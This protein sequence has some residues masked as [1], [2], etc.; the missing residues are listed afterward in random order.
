MSETYDIEILYR[1]PTFEIRGPGQEEPFSWTYSL[2]A[3]SPDAA[4]RQALA[5]FRAIAAA[6]WVS[7]VRNIVELR[8]RSSSPQAG[9]MDSLIRSQL[10][11]ASNPKEAQLDEESRATLLELQDQLLEELLVIKWTRLRDAYLRSGRSGRRNGGLERALRDLD[12]LNLGAWEPIYERM[13]THY[14]ESPG[15]CYQLQRLFGHEDLDSV[16]EAWRAHFLEEVEALQ[17]SD[18]FVA[19]ALTLATSWNQASL[20]ALLEAVEEHLE[21]RYA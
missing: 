21:T 19:L 14:R 1:E 12:R 11:S 13:A 8:L 3:R 7:W 2:T 9:W 18:A 5:Q 17:K 15:A 6:S 10:R 4:V 20:E 16:R